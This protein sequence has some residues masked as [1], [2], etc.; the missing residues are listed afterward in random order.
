M[1]TR[2]V[3]GKMLR[4]GFT[5]GSCAAAAAKA[6]ASMLLTQT[7]CP[8]VTLTTPGGIFLSLNVR[9]GELTSAYASCAIQK[10]SGDDPDVTNGCL[11]YARVSFLPEGIEISGGEG[12][13]L[14]TRPGL[15]QP[16]GAHAI[17][18]GPRRQIKEECESVCRR[19]GY[20]GG[21][22]VVITIPN[23][24]ELSKRTFNPRMGIKGGL[25]ILGTS[26][27]VEP[28]SE[29]AIVETI[30]AQLSLLYEA[31][32]RE[33]VLTIGNYGEAF[34][35]DKLGLSL[36]SHVKCSNF[37]G[38]TLAAAAE[39][40]FQQVL[41]IGH[42]GKL[43]KLGIGITNTHSSH[44]GGQIETLITCALEAGASLYLLHN[45]RSC[46]STDAALHYLREAGL[47][48]ETMDLLRERIKETLRRHVAGTLKIHLICFGGT[49]ENREELFTI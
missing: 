41:L 9:N 11:V 5:T 25:S 12:I 32:H 38:D 28:M 3:G 10:D 14:V 47:L 4:R 45:I 48:K 46:V 18:S 30:R 34:A 15:D 2:L 1:D 23:G 40:G 43:S 21:L 19:H 8:I 22:L 39:K 13:G 36:V 42:I 24:L 37:I 31:G 29:K 33:V 35:K 6:A 17:N 7:D 16:V 44:S 20:E 26:G 49:G 27:I